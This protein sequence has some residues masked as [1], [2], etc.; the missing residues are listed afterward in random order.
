MNRRDKN[1]LHEHSLEVWDVGP[2]PARPHPFP[3]YRQGVWLEG[4]AQRRRRGGSAVTDKLTTA[5]VAEAIGIKPAT[6]RAYVSRGQ[7]PEPDGW[8]DAR[9]P[10]WFAATIHEWNAKRPKA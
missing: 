9:T 8:H 2:P 3:V 7:A 1:R 10:W 5:Q 4:V 6:F